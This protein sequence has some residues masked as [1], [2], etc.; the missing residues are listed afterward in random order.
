MPPA[1]GGCHRS[2]KPG[3]PSLSQAQGRTQAAVDP[4][5]LWGQAPGHWYDL[6]FPQPRGEPG[7]G[8]S[9]TARGLPRSTQH[10]SSGWLR[11][12]RPSTRSFI[13]PSTRS[14]LPPSFTRPPRH[15]DSG[16]QAAVAGTAMSGSRARQAPRAVDWETE[17]GEGGESAPRDAHARQ[18]PEAAGL[19]PGRPQGAVQTLPDPYRT[20]WSWDGPSELLCLAHGGLTLL[21]W[22]GAWGAGEALGSISGCGRSPSVSQPCQ[23]D[24]LPGSAGSPLGAPPHAGPPLWHPGR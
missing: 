20:F 16:A 1:S 17:P 22:P 14:S 8:P 18:E 21:S 24:Q 4:G 19:G 3:K 12:P 7:A 11:L 6:R 2:G 15:Q 9:P 23:T 10:H 13:C 5:G